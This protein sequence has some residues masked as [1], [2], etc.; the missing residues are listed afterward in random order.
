MDVLVTG[1][2]GYI[3]SHAVQQLL[4][5]GHEVTVYDDLSQ[6]H[7]GAVPA[8]RLVVGRL[9]DRVRL[10]Q[11]MRVRGIEA[12]MHFA[13]FTSVP[14]SVADPEKYYANNVTGSL[15][16]FGAM[17][18]AGVSRCVFSSTA[19]VYGRPTRIPIDE[20]VTTAPINPYGFTKLAVERALADFCIAHGWAAA[21]LRYFN[22]AGAS[23]TDDIGE[24]HQPETHLIPVVLQVAL[25]LRKAIQVYGNDYPTPDGTCI[26]DYIHVDD[27]ASAHVLAL[28][29]LA[30]GE[31]LA[32]NLG[33]GH[34]YSVREVLDMCREITGRNIPEQLV[35]RRPGDPASLVADATKAQT[36]LGWKPECSDLETIVETAWRW[37]RAHPRGYAETHCI[38]A[39]RMS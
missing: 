32:A 26:R 22:A 15:S 19:A 33:V 12:V 36:V 13:A 11:L 29:R 14:E 10:A 30:E 3:G 4:A 17:R 7:V 23:R 25:G 21:A 8:G 9:H 20:Q 28:E 37:H 31:F 16:L 2:A 1:G 18:D 38:P 35:T 39:A 24:D 27:L 34:G 5:A 6:G